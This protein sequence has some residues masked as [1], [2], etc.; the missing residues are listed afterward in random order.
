VGPF[1]L[2]FTAGALESF[3]SFSR[4]DRV[5]VT[6]KLQFLAEFP[7]QQPDSQLRNDRGEVLDVKGLGRW[8][9]AYSV[10]FP[11]K[12]IIVVRI[13]KIPRAKSRKS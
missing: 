9:I 10:D 2:L 3:G 8:L 6:E 7:L 13:I 12:I 11:A 4:T 1:R 5:S